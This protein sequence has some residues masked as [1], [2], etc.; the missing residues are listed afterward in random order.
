MQNLFEKYAHKEIAIEGAW[1]N[2]LGTVTD[3][4]VLDYG[5][6]FSGHT[7]ENLPFPDDGVHGAATEYAAVLE[8]IDHA[9]MLGRRSFAMAEMGAGWGPWI[10]NAGV[11]AKRCDFDAIH[12][13]GVEADEARFQTMEQHFERNGLTG[14]ERIHPRLYFGAIW[15]EKTT[16]RFPKV[17]LHDYGAAATASTNEYRGKT[18]EMVEVP[19][20]TL[21]ECT[22]NLGIID[23]MHWDI[24]GAE[25]SL[26][27]AT[28]YFLNKRVRSLHI[29]THSRAIE[30]RLFT[31]LDEMGW[32]I[33]RE[34]PCKMHHRRDALSLEDMNTMDGEIYARNP[35]LWDR[36]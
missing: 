8:A 23:L 28:R 5:M 13:I 35:A 16:L 18:V 4:S 12:L 33:L 3:C 22:G 36:P 7:H 19:T 15:H 26:A 2:F 30:G 6:M 29:G 31:V 34:T 17:P 11:V 27:E 21:E 32:E 25:A 1:S 20:W 10:A 14:D 9:L 24:Q